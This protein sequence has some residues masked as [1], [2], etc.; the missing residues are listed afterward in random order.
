MFKKYQCEGMSDVLF[1]LIVDPPESAM[2][3]SLSET[4]PQ[5]L[6]AALPENPDPTSSS[7][8]ADT[9]FGKMTLIVC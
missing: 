6:S 2:A 8:P 7:L 9:D 5:N 1:T 3:N 4:Q